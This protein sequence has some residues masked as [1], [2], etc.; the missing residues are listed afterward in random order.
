MDAKKTLSIDK[1]LLDKGLLSPEQLTSAL[2]YQCR[3]PRS[4][5]M[6]LREVLVAMEYVTEEQL[7][8]ALGEKSSAEDVIVRELI[9]DGVLD[10]AQLTQAINALESTHEEKRLGTVV[11]ELGL[12]TRE[13][14]ED[15]LKQYY[16]NREKEGPPQ[17]PP[18]PS[19]P[20][21]PRA[22]EPIGQ[23]LIRKGYL[24]AT[25]LQDA[26]DYQYRLPRLLHKPL[27][28]ILILLGYI[29]DNQLQAAL[30]EQ[31]QPE[32]DPLGQILVS[33]GLIQQWQLSHVLTL[34]YEPQH[35]NKKIGM[36]LV[37]MGYARRPDIEAT[38]K[39]YYARQALRQRAS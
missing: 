26:I 4:Q 32:T 9:R 19:L 5:A 10:E 38:L 20:V 12:S 31:T 24:R 17:P 28:E 33:M 22:R 11:L 25:E 1:I 16:Q 18:N 21:G 30:K 14:I 8:I 35:A 23:I 34:K 29:D 37:E 13:Q 7:Q 3:L 39:E 36:L 6:S 27:G 15:A 2:Q